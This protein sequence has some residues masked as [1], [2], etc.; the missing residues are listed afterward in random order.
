[1]QAAHQSM[2]AEQQALVE[3]STER[4]R[5]EIGR[6]AEKLVEEVGV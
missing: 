3:A 1:M 4:G 6:E 2:L 5:Q